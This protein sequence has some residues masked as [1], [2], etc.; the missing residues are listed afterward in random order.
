MFLS[1]YTVVVS[2]WAWD[3]L[4][5]SISLHYSLRYMQLMGHQDIEHKTPY[6]LCSIRGELELST[7]GRPHLIS[8]GKNN[9]LCIPLLTF[10]DAFGLYRNMYRSLM[11]IYATIAALNWRERRR[12]ANVLPLALGPHATNFADVIKVLKS[13]RFQ[14][15]RR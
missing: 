12:R 2:F 13:G 1:P 3:R 8:F 10:I 6:A 4:L 7:Y 5:Q 15:C 11:G 14:E 9:T